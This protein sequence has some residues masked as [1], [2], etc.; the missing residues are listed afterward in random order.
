MQ[1]RCGSDTRRMNPEGQKTRMC[2]RLADERCSDQNR[3]GRRR[4]RIDDARA[5]V[6]GRD[7]VK[8]G[9]EHRSMTSGDRQSDR[10]QE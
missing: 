10:N 9:P 6:P 5:N 2:T 1:R 7:P 3:E 8:A 4:I